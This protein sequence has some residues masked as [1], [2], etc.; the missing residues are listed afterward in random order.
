MSTVP[1]RTIESLS[2]EP[3]RV[4]GAAD[5][6]E[7]QRPQRDQGED[8]PLARVRA[9]PH[10]PFRFRPGPRRARRPPTRRRQ[11]VASRRPAASRSCTRAR[12]GSSASARSRP[13]AYS[14]AG[15]RSNVENARERIT[16]SA[17]S[18]VVDRSDGSSRSAPRA[19]PAR[20]ELGAQRSARSESAPDRDPAP[21][22]RSA[23]TTRDRS[24]P[25]PRSRSRAGPWGASTRAAWGNARG[26]VHEVDRHTHHDGVEPALLE[27]ERLGPSDRALTPSAF[28]RSTI[29]AEASIAQT[30]AWSRSC[31]RLREPSG[32]ATDLE[33]AC[34]AQLA[35]PNER[36]RRPPT[37]S[38]RRAGA[39]R[40]A[41]RG[42][43]IRRSVTPPGSPRAAVRVG[44]RP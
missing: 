8:E 24:S 36:R 5:A 20:T 25:G 37:S 29:A 28:A 16:S 7:R 31:E 11:A 26:A 3:A 12:S 13:A 9:E 2:R 44:R 30:R 22:G 14:S 38:R 27:R 19:R 6:D 10:R 33:H 23:R 4:L 39:P 42:R 40:S 34:S 43:R 17:C 15:S 32:A 21:T 18:R 1:R 41:R 35:E